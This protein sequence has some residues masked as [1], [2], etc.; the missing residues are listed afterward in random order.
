VTNLLSKAAHW[1]AIG[2]VLDFRDLHVAS[3]KLNSEVCLGVA[4]LWKRLARALCR[5]R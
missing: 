2:D 5:Q 4:A 3:T 1:L